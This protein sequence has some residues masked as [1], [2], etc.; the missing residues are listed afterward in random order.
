MIETSAV[1]YNGRR[2]ASWRAAIIKH[3]T[4]GFRHS[5]SCYQ[6]SVD[7]CPINM[8]NPDL[9][10]CLHQFIITVSGQYLCSSTRHFVKIRAA[11][12]NYGLDLREVCLRYTHSDLTADTWIVYIP[13]IKCQLWTC[14][15]NIA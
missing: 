12:Q 9:D 6:A 5:C 8:H 3:A 4:L 13:H 11:Q 7:T 14:L 1:K 2:P 10:S 15:R